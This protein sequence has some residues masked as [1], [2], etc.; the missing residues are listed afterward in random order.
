M[1]CCVVNYADGGWY[2]RGSLRLHDSLK[3]M[4]FRGSF[5]QFN[6]DTAY[7]CLTHQESPYAFKYWA[8]QRARELRFDCALW[9][10]SSF[11]AIRSLDDLFEE[12]ND[13]GYVFQQSDFKLGTWCS[14]AALNTFK[15][16]RDEAMNI[17]MYDG[18]F[19]GLKFSNNK[20][21]EFLNQMAVIS[22][23]GK[24]FQGAWTNENQQVSK[25]PRVMGHR[26]DMSVGTMLVR[27]MKM[28]PVP[29]GKYWT[30]RFN[31]KNFKDV[32]LLG[33]GM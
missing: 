27:K 29:E 32:C 11:W 18:G 3:V 2:P 20:A 21:S 8:M 12:I 25:D 23:D 5:L 9:L 1:E 4:K 17:K 19:F 30:P 13:V 31:H 33:E 7:E 14:D 24:S 26:H 6:K 28:I 15:V 16:S 22:K 10:D